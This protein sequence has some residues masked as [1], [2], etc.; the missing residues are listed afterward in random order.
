M[1]TS[2]YLLIISQRWDW[3]FGQTPEFTYTVQNAFSWGDVVSNPRRSLPRKN[4][5]SPQTA[6]LHSK[7]GIILDCTLQCSST[8]SVIEASLQ[9]LGTRLKGQRYAFV[10][11][12]QLGLEGS[13]MR[14][15]WQWLENV[16][17]S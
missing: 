16:M 3:A 15:V 17:S 2:D 13:N 5:H 14:E 10:D 8:D 11:I 9:E 1:L 4:A 12:E 6:K 7:H